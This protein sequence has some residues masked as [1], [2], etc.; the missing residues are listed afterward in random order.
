[1]LT[2]F[3]R[4]CAASGIYG[5]SFARSSQAP[6]P[7]AFVA[8]YYEKI[9]QH[10]GI[11]EK[12]INRWVCTIEGNTSLTSNDSGGADYRRTSPAAA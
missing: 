11:V 7:H 1:M 4:K 9:T 10:V 2:D 6:L 5:H 8:Q 12:I 3:V